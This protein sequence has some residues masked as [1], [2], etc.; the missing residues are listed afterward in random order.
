LDFNEIIVRFHLLFDH[1]YIPLPASGEGTTTC[2]ELCRAED[3]VVHGYVRCL[4]VY[5]TRFL[6]G[7]PEPGDPRKACYRCSDD[8][9]YRSEEL[10]AD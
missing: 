4:A 10:F 7:L 6:G 8:R 2:T 3:A 9:V 1:P 5:P